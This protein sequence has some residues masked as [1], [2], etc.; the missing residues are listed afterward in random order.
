[1]PVPTNRLIPQLLPNEFF[2]EKLIYHSV[3]SF[4]FFLLLCQPQLI[5]IRYFCFFHSLTIFFSLFFSSFF[6][7]E[8][9]LSLPA[10]FF[11]FFQFIRHRSIVQNL[12]PVQR[13]WRNY[14]NALNSLV[15]F[16]LFFFYPFLSLF[17]FFPGRWKH[18]K[19]L[20]CYFVCFYFL[21]L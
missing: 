6:Y 19:R 18:I 1:M 8:G 11:F 15:S 7:Q 9:N 13:K 16:L 4:F 14:R 17:L 2:Q 20:K 12:L 3:T 10:F 21:I 5:W